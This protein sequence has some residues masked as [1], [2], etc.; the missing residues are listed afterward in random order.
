MT[1]NESRSLHP[2]TFK[3]DVAER[4]VRRRLLNHRRIRA[5]RERFIVDP[6]GGMIG[7]GVFEVSIPRRL[8]IYRLQCSL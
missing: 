6:A 7:S 8:F 1:T 5:R 3:I 4:D 2:L